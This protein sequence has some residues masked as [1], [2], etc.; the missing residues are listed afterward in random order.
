M[1][2][3]SAIPGE[4]GALFTTDG[5]CSGAVVA[6]APTSPQP[7][8][9]LDDQLLQEPSSF[10][11]FQAVRLFERLEP[12]RKPVG[13][14]ASSGNEIIRFRVPATTAF[15]ASSI[16]RIDPAT[17]Q[18]PVPEMWVNFMGLTGPSGVLPAH[19]TE[20]LVRRH[21]DFRGSERYV[22]QDWLDLFNH[23]LIS[24][25]YRAW[26]KYRFWI[27]FE[28]GEYN[29]QNP[30]SF[31][32]VLRSLIG[33]GT[34]AM[35]N[36]LR[37]SIPE[38]SQRYEPDPQP[39][40]PQIQDLSLLRYAGLLAQRCRSA[41]NL[42]AILADYF[43]V[44]VTVEQFQGQ[45]LVLE[46]ADQ[47]QLGSDDSTAMLGTGAVI[48]PRVWDVQGKFRVRLGPLTYQ[49]FCAF[50]PDRSPTTQRKAFFLLSQLV[51]LFAGPEFDFDI[52]LVLRREDVPPTQL[53]IDDELG[54]R[55]GW[56]TWL[57]GSPPAEDAHDAIIAAQEVCPV[58]DGSADG[59]LASLMT[60]PQT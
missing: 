10:D 15:P 16:E 26:E 41:A 33:L 27:P 1:S 8:N 14:R 57:C 28:R 38:M 5:L 49:Q 42:Q 31:T 48:G 19:Y 56:N 2:S 53:T 46:D 21:L 52:Q 40:E 54:S 34:P 20:L 23:R 30:D 7:S 50:F 22:L 35:R 25:F 3:D 32:R 43:L 44:P 18:H 51:R 55:L 17:E 9:N 13:R 36:R 29:R 24:L 12:T 4:H 6:S 60:I 45:W 37:V 11:F 39:R 58:E 59:Q 47:S